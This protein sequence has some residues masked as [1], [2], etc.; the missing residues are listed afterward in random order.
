MTAPQAQ[1]TPSR[2]LSLFAIDEIADIAAGELHSADVA[3]SAAPTPI[4]LDE[5]SGKIVH[6][7]GNE[8]LAECPYPAG[9]DGLI[10]VEFDGELYEVD[11][12]AP[13]NKRGP[14]VIRNIHR[15]IMFKLL[16]NMTVAQ[17]AQELDKSVGFIRVIINSPMFKLEMRKLEKKLEEKVLDVPSRA[18]ALGPNALNVLVDAMRNAPKYADKIVA[19]DKVLRYG[20]NEPVKKTELEMTLNVGA[21]HVRNVASAWEL[22]KQQLGGELRRVGVVQ[23]VSPPLEIEATATAVAIADEDN[24]NKPATD[25]VRT[26]DVFTALAHD[27]MSELE[28]DAESAEFEREANTIA[29]NAIANRTLADIYGKPS[30]L[31]SRRADAVADEFIPNS[32]L[33]NEEAEGLFD[34]IMSNDDS[35]DPSLLNE[36]AEV[37]KKVQ[38][39]QQTQ[40][41]QFGV[42]KQQREAVAA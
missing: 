32:Y 38:P 5:Q 18:K 19:A 33:T 10:R 36:L 23:S 41:E 37:K 21:G 27:A 14:L 3:P 11:P 29:D 7:Y 28:F 42:G 31:A 8:A 15:Q 26:N 24:S 25:R 1:S 12:S 17:I 34:K 4:R 39:Q 20:G 35:I 16:M 40:S 2:Q 22:R 30:T 9:E 13:Y 6:G